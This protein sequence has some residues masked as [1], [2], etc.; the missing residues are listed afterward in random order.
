LLQAVS[1]APENNVAKCHG[2]TRPDPWQ[3]AT[4]Q[5]SYDAAVDFQHTVDDSSFPALHDREWHEDK[6][7]QGGWKCPD[8]LE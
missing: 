1:I 3:A 7:K 6:S 4:E 8:V 5:S 2:G